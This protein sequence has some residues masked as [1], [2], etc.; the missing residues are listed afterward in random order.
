MSPEV[1]K[2]KVKIAIRNRPESQVDFYHIL[3]QFWPPFWRHF[4]A[5]NRLF[6]ALFFGPI[7]KTIL[8]TKRWPKLN[9]PASRAR[10]WDPLEL[11]FRP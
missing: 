7:F 5:Q 3:R 10:P 9:E 4:G 11:C 2:I 1:G 8:G 6:S